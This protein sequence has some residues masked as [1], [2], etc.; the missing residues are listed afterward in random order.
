MFFNL[1]IEIKQENYLNRLETEVELEIRFIASA[2][3]EEIDIT[4]IFVIF[5][6]FFNYR[7]SQL[8]LIFLTEI[9]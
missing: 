8:L 9:F 7:S 6:I 4:S 2:I 3:I 1:S 5:L